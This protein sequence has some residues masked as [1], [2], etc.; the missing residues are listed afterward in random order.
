LK[1]PQVAKWETFVAPVREPAVVAAE[2]PRNEGAPRRPAVHDDDEEPAA[3][4]DLD[5]EPILDT[6]E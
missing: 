3:P 2:R 5:D 6:D 4:K 1:H